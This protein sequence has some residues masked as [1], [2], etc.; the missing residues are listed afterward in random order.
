MF[1]VSAWV[2]MPGPDLPCKMSSF[3]GFQA[4]PGSIFFNIHLPGDTF[5][6][7]L[8]GMGPEKVVLHEAGPAKRRG[9]LSP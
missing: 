9:C 6:S 5:W 3:D 8:E 2:N 7:S 1:Q 4:L